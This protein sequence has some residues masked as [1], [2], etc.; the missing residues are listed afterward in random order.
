MALNLRTVQSAVVIMGRRGP[1]VGIQ[2]TGFIAAVPG[3][4]RSDW[5]YTCI[6][7]AHHIVDGLADPIGVLI[8][9]PLTNGSYHAPFTVVKDWRQPFPGVDLA[10]ARLETDP[11]RPI[12]AIA[13]D[14]VMPTDNAPVGGPVLRM[15]HPLLG[16]P[17]CYVGVFEPSQRIMVRSGTIGAIDQEG[18]EHGAPY[19]YPAHLVDRRSY[20]GFSGSPASLKSLLRGLSRVK[21]HPLCH[22]EWNWPPLG[23]V[24]SIA[25]LCGMFTEHYT[26]E[27]DL[28][29][30]PESI[31]IR[32]GVGVM[33][34]GNEIKRALMTEEARQERRQLDADALAQQE[35]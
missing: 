20:G 5:P 30:N 24:L 10:I 22:P 28:D 11:K 3:E 21:M 33:L 19:D 9:N 23:G 32:Y 15:A 34:R 14:A 16:A 8:P 7:T 29:T 26:D 2:G 17:M 13:I 6:L 31:V 27:G 25:L 18:L 4:L 12:S 35:K 1:H